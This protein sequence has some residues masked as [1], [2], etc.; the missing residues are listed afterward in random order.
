[1]DDLRADYDNP[2]KEAIGCYFKE[3]MLLLFPKIFVDIDWSKGYTFLDKELQQVVRDAELG[4]RRADKL[5]KVWRK[6][7]SETWILVHI[8]VQCQ[9]ESEFAKRMYIYN[10]RLFDKYNKQIVSLAILGDERS[11]WRPAHYN[12]FL[13]GCKLDFHFPIIKLI[14]YEE[15]W[16][17]LESSENPFAVIIMAYLKALRT[18]KNLKDRLWWKLHLVKRLY[19]KGYIEQEI[20]ELFRFIDWLLILPEDLENSFG[21]T[22]IEYEEEKKMPY[23]TSIER[24]GIKKGLE[25]GLEQGLEKGLERGLEKG[26]EKGIIQD[27][28]ESIIDILDVRFGKI[29]PSLASK[30]YGLRDSSLLRKLRKNA[31]TIESLG[32]FERMI[33]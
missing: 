32:E 23:I 11:N 9:Y 6:D 3:F 1:M 24:I 31:V 4:E 12:S 5:V 10:Y 27:A 14:D 25:Q 7:G 15:N 2:W 8:E 20:L 19:E 26:L 22:L 17:N 29:T 21:Q 30:I 33:P 16:D 18:K 13:W 28:Q